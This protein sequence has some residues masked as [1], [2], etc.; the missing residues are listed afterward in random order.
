LKDELSKLPIENW[1]HGRYTGAGQAKFHK[2]L[3]SEKT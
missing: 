1:L 3:V 2:I